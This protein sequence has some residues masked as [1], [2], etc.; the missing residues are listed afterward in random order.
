MGT[1]EPRPFGRPLPNVRGSF[2]KLMVDLLG[3]FKLRGKPKRDMKAFKSY[4]IRG[5][6]PEE[7]NEKLAFKV[8]QA[9]AHFL[10]A[11]D[12][13]V[14]FDMRESSPSLFE[15]LTKGMMSQGV[16]VINIGMVTTP[17]LSFAVAR[18]NYD[19]GI[20]ISASHNPGEY[21][22]FKVIGKRGVQLSSETGLNTLKEL[23]QQTF[24]SKNPGVMVKKGVMHDYLNHVS[25]F[26]KNHNLKVVADYGNGVGAIS[27]EPFFKRM[28]IEVVP[29]Y[30]EPDGSFPNHP[31][32]PHDVE[33]LQ[34]L[35]K[36]VVEEKAD[37]G[38][39]FD[40]DADRVVVVDEKGEIV[41]ADLL[42]A[43]LAQEELKQH[44]NEKV[45]FDLRF[46]KV[47]PEIIT[48]NHG[49]PIMMR[50]GNPFYKEKLIHEGGI[51]AGEF[52]GHIM[53]KENYGIDDGL[54]ATIKTMNLLQ[55]ET[56][57]SLVNTMKR[58]KNTPEINLKVKDADE[59]LRK[60]A[61]KFQGGESISIDGVHISYK[62]WWFS[63]RK[64]NTEPLVRL[65]IEADSTELL[66]EK[67][68]EIL[69]MLAD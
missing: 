53:F 14:G 61:A 60:V 39:F 45:Y 20:M 8:G 41:Y 30:P 47:V 58:Y 28:G 44:Q 13:V 4:D 51:L 6:Y 10:K 67:K 63:L 21:N 23:S 52:S 12:I 65:R 29:M 22:A 1:D 42:L 19:G 9:F 32:N 25:S 5:L 50:V 7:I 46:S 16:N 2:I 36:K 56:L 68:A 15:H 62:D 66:E 18:Y 11:K 3:F 34:D 64:S 38:L 27:A 43:L 35:Q 37:L 57:S 26:S 48:A 33:N 54:F 55:N 31:A 69:E 40:G 17:M 24:D 49:I 59:S